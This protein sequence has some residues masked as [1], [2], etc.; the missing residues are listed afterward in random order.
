[1]ALGDRIGGNLTVRTK[2]VV[3]GTRIERAN[4]DP[5]VLEAMK[6]PR[7]PRIEIKHQSG[8]LVKPLVQRTEEIESPGVQSWVRDFE[9]L[10]TLPAPTERR[11]DCLQQPRDILAPHIYR[12]H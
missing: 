7:T 10:P 11:A 1:M 12:C 8:W 9:E 4:N 6:I 2:T 5:P 3:V